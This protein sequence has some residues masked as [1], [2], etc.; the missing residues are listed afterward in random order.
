MHGTTSGSDII[1]GDTIRIHHNTFMATGPLNAFP[2]AIR[3]V[4]RDGAYIDHNWFYYTQAPPVWQT[5]GQG[6][7]SVT[8]NLIG[9]NRTFSASG[10]IEYY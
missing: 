6:K 8:E 10:P 4:P 1:A 2:V 5:G 9:K 7:V 3:G